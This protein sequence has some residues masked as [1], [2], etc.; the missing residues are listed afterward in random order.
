MDSDTEEGRGPAGRRVVIIVQQESLRERPRVYKITKV[1]RGLGI[2]FEIWKFGEGN[3]PKIVDIPVRNLASSRVKSWPSSLRYL[4]WMTLVARNAFRERSRASFYAIGFD[5]A[6]PVAACVWNGAPLLFDNID[7]VSLSYRWPFGL[8]HVFAALERWVAR[9]ARTHVVPSVYRWKSQD[10]NLHVVAN[11]PSREVVGE[12][13]AIASAG[14][15]EPRAP[16][17]LYLNGWLSGTRGIATL[18]EAIALLEQQ[19]RDVRV[20]VAGRPACGDA[21]RLLAM[22]Q[23]ENLGMLTNAEALATYRRAHLAF[24]YYDPAVAINRV[25]ESQKWTDCWAMGTPFVVNNG[26]LPV[27]PYKAAGGCFV[28][29]YFDAPGLASLVARLADDPAQLERARANLASMDFRYWDD[30]M[31][32]VARHWLALS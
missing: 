12:A 19:G 11:T 5:S 22:K 23:V 16:L 26:V 9:R 24:T 1:L 31:R 14:G 15:F 21:Q 3:D 32:R 30:E 25:A 8:K 29:N 6:A 17:T 7:N 13:S 2:P 18:C 28:L 10:P 4:Y 20:L 27:E